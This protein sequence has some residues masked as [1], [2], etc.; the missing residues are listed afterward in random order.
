MLTKVFN[1]CIRLT[2]T[3]RKNFLCF[4]SFT[5][6]DFAWSQ[7]WVKISWFLLGIS[8]NLQYLLLFFFFFFLL[9]CN[10]LL[11]SLNYISLPKNSAWSDWGCCLLVEPTPFLQLYLEIIQIHLL[12]LSTPVLVI[13]LVVHHFPYLIQCLQWVF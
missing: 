5:S 2:E 4:W 7:T 12:R 10:I 13:V 9:S 11:V 3:F 6:W 1:V 8:R